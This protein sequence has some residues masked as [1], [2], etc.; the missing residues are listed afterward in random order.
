M[1][2]E[3]K[4]AL[5]TGAARGQGRSHAVRLAEEGADI[6]AV[7]VPKSDFQGVSY[8][9]GTEADLAE[10]VA[11]VEATGRRIVAEEADIRDLEGLTRA[12]ARGVD[13]FGRLDIVVANAGIWSHGGGKTH[14]IEPSTWQDVIDVNLTGTWHTVKAAMPHMIVGERGGAVVLI[15]S[16]AGLKGFENIAHYVASKHGIVGLMRTLAIE[17]AEY[18]IRVNTLHTT[19][20]DTK[21]V[22]N[23]S[24]FRLFL[25][26]V[27]E[28]TLE[29]FTAAS[30][31]INALPVPW[32]DPIDV[33]NAVVFLAS[34][35]ARYITGTTLPVDAGV[36]AK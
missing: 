4:V 27:D 7:D 16:A 18:S 9:L 31:G 35:G 21:M 3:G 33:S 6:I 34:E 8:P 2:V 23:D 32:I 12:V 29:Q 20:V 11:L 1:L 26:D 19:N 22:M 28:P 15:S 14:E 13:V 24:I 36:L 30:Q 25:P 17:L 10:T 5:V